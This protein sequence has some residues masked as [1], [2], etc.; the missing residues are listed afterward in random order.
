MNQ[1]RKYKTDWEPEFL[2]EIDVSVNGKTVQLSRGAKFSVRRRV[3]L[4]AGKYEFVYAER[5]V[6][7]ALLIFADGP[8][9]R[10]RRRKMIRESD[11]KTVDGAK[12]KTSQRT[13]PRSQ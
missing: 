3:G 11:I 7:G 8:C 13:P 4:I 1:K 12:K 9:S 6:G 10:E 5:A 2:H